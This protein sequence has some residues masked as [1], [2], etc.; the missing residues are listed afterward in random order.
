MKCISKHLEVRTLNSLK[1]FS[2]Y[3]GGDGRWVPLTVLRHVLEN[4]AISFQFGALYEALR[5]QM[6]KGSRGMSDY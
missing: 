2:M 5:S 3:F 6:A 4:W 1:E